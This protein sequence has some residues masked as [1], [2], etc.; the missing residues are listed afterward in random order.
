MPFIFAAIAGFI[1]GAGAIG[2]WL[3]TRWQQQ[4]QEA[5]VSLQEIADQHQEQ[6]K[7][8]HTLKQQVADLE[9][10]LKRAQNDLQ[11]QQQ[12]KQH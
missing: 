11:A 12:S 9:Y 3:N 8:S 5:N 10:Q 2:W 1:I 4:V 7:Q 6:I